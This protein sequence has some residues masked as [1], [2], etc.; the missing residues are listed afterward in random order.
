MIKLNAFLL[1]L[2]SLVYSQVTFAIGI[3]SD[4]TGNKDIEFVSMEATLSS[5]IIHFKWDVEKEV[6][7]DYFL[8]EKSTDK[9]N[10]KRVTQVTS[11]GN[12]K[13][14]HTYEVSE[15]N[16]AEGANE[17]F[18]IKRVDN[19]G[20]ESILDMVNISHPV[21]T[22][23]M[24]VPIEANKLM[25]ISYDSK[26]S[27]TARITVMNSEGEIAF[28]ENQMVTEGYNRLELNIKSFK[29]GVYFVLIKD[30]FE[31]KLSKR[32]TIYGKR[33]KRK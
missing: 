16:F 14:R 30:D 31:N 9:Q 18:R 4:S 17:Y 21:L 20:N 6:K 3:D 32:L 10:W 1:I 15:I 19:M 33:G 5:K 27:S 23:L 12:H 24:L 7:G 28:E 13:E 22:N 2:F 29:E 26:I 25:S 11:L 8:I